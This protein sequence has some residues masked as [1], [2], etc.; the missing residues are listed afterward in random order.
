MLTPAAACAALERVF[1]EAAEA[2]VIASTGATASGDA[3]AAAAMAVAVEDAL[4]FADL[5]FGCCCGLL[6]VLHDQLGEG[7]VLESATAG[8]D[9]TADTGGKSDADED[10]DDDEGGWSDNS[11][12]GLEFSAT[13]WGGLCWSRCSR[14]W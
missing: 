11:D 14:G 1:R 10:D 4:G 6:D 2:A 13:H 3:A 9:A 5:Q 12:E 7:Q 8:G